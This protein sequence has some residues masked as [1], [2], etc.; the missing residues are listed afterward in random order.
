MFVK[1]ITLLVLVFSLFISSCSD[2]TSTEDFGQITGSVTFVGSWPTY[3]DV[4]VSA[5]TEWPPAGPPSAASIVFTSGVNPQDYTIE[6]LSKGT[7]QATWKIRQLLTRL[8]Q[9]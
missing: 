5:W 8:Q 1:F 9:G 6:G 3:G 4:Q 7:Y 2:S